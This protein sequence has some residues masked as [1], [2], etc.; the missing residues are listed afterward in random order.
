MTQ[1]RDDRQALDALGRVVPQVAPPA[2]LRA[3]VLAAAAAMPQDPPADAPTTAAVATDRPALPSAGPRAWLLVAA[4]V[5]AAVSLAG[6]ASARGEVARLQALVAD[7]RS[8][9]QT[10]LAMR[11]DFDA[12]QT[13]RQRAARILGAADV[14]ATTLAG[15]APA[16]AAHARVYLSRTHGLLAIAEALPA[17]S[18]GRVYQLWTIVGGQPFSNG[19]LEVD[20]AGRAQLL[21]GAPPG[22]AE[23]YAVTI[24]PA[25]GVPAPTGDR[26]LL[27]VAGN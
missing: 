6:W 20:A 23:A 18:G 8:Q 10:L 25:G 12:E 21:T 13:A 5:V 11:A 24:E 7:L 1:D 2:E 14:R 26:V 9:A 15:Q 27:G 19:L 22:E 17:L 16:T 3:R 4:T